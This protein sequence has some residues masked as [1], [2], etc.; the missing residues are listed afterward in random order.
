MPAKSGASK[1]RFHALT[2]SGPGR[3]AVLPAPLNPGIFL[4]CT[5]RGEA[6]GTAQAPNGGERTRRA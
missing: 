5:S 2:P 4:T 6:G 1:A 3:G